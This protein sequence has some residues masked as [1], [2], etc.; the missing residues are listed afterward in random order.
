MSVSFSSGHFSAGLRLQCLSTK[1]NRQTFDPDHVARA[2]V[3]MDASFRGGTGS[4]AGV[5][6]VA[7][8]ASAAVRAVDL[9]FCCAIF[10]P[11]S[12]D[13]LCVSESES[14][15]IFQNEFSISGL[16]SGVYS[17]DVRRFLESLGFSFISAQRV[18]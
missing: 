17:L 13:A 3:D 16:F 8:P 15:R 4:R 7:H 14:R 2:L 6:H 18:D 1:R 12:L 11:Q 10:L 5:N 9:I